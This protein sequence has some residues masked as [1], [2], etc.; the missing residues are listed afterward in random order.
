MKKKNSETEEI[1]KKKVFYLSFPVFPFKL[2]SIA[3]FMIK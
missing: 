3:G 1:W 2:I